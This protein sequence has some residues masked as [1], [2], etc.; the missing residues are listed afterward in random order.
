MDVFN[1]IVDSMLLLYFAAFSWAPPALSLAVLAALAGIAMLWIFRK[2][3]DQSRLRAVKN[4]VWAALLEL[5]VY[6]DE[7]R[8]TWRAQKAL[9]AANLRYIGLALRPAM[10]MLVPMALLLIHLES[11]YG[12]APL[13]AG[14]ETIVTMRM[15]PRWNPE[16]PPP[17]MAAPPE[18]NVV[19]PPVRAVAAREVSW[20]IEAAQPVSGH[21][22]FVIDG[23]TVTKRIEAGTR[24]RFVPGRSVSS[25]VEELWSPGEHRIA[26]NNV[27]WIE[28]RYPEA[29]L[30]AL[31][32]EWNWLVWFF[33][34]STAVALL[35]KRYFGV[36]I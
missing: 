29:R 8:I 36:V 24:Q 6:G 35:L 7:P 27:E 19:G 3:S 26:A 33:V 15:S 17:K 16:S 18:V 23:N 2:T 1:A 30:A 14:S 22:T 28:I 31:G 25:A 32:I 10:W 11:F 4:K 9:F 20:R 21:L 12:R 5:R 34:V 13:P